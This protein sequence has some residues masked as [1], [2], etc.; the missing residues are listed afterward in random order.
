MDNVDHRVLFHGSGLLRRSLGPVPGLCS[1]A[2]NT[3]GTRLQPRRPSTWHLSFGPR[4]LSHDA[5]HG[6]VLRCACGDHM[7]RHDERRSSV[8]VAHKVVLVMA[9]GTRRNRG[10]VV[11]QAHQARRRLTNELLPY[12]RHNLRSLL[13]CVQPSWPAVP[14]NPFYIGRSFLARS[15]GSDLGQYLQSPSPPIVVVGTYSYRGGQK[16]RAGVAFGAAD[17]NRGLEVLLYSTA[18]L[19][20][21]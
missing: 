17:H 9:S 12:H 20:Q 5:M 2:T 1:P 4:H 10:L 6:F 16:S 13:K 8:V 14:R 7:P 11:P 21:F 15:L 3:V 18:A 19:L